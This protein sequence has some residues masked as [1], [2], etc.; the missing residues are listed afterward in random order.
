MT[1][2]EI[3]PFLPFLLAAIACAFTRG[4]LTSFVVLAVPLIGAL[5]LYLMPTEY[6]RQLQILSFELALVRVDKLS[7]MFGYLFHIAAF[8]SIIYC[9]HVKDRMHQI[10]CMVYLAS[11][12]GAVFSG[13]LLSL[14]I[15][16]ELMVISSVFLILARR[17]PDAYSAGLRY[18]VY[19]FLSGLLLLIGT[20]LYFQQHQDLTFTLMELEGAAAWFIFI[21]F[22]IKCAFPMLHSWLTDAYP[23]ATPGGSVFLSALT[24]KVAVYTLARGFA[25]SEILVYIGA[26]MTCFPIFYAVIEND[27]RRVLSYSLINQLGFMVVG[28]GVGTELA[29]NGAV[30]T[31]FNHVLYKG[32]LFM[33]MGAV[34][35]MTGCIKASE[36]GGLYKTMPKTTLLCVIGA[37]SISAFPLFNGFVSKSMVI[38]AV[39][40]ENYEWVWLTLIFASAGV[41]HHAGIKIPYFAFFAKDSGL[42]SQDPPANMLI[43]MAIAAALCIAIGI[44]P[45]LLYQILP[46]DLNYYPYDLSH[47]LAQTQLLCFA[48]L[49][50]VWLNLKGIYPKELPSVNLGP[51]WFY[52]KLMPSIWRKGNHMSQAASAAAH[53]FI[54]NKIL[55]FMALLEKYHGKDGILSRNQSVGNL[56]LW[57]AI[58]LACY[59]ALSFIGA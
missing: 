48:A 5:N 42:R 38:S 30:S 33:S 35:H 10:A 32:L 39:L 16:W 34:L 54:L 8:F 19:Q 1:A 12:L 24:T 37:A 7:L 4:R 55:A 47:V 22:G 11:A 59:L 49:A 25:G 3:P 53:Q 31:A 58:L 20:A 2:L 26:V 43:A 27:L 6:S 46:Y 57:V 40:T 52:R 28:I 51:E 14:L 9:L 18:F 17:T 13:D 41:F 36:L 23:E 15:F 29:L 56:A 45:N 50:F 21:A 44:Y